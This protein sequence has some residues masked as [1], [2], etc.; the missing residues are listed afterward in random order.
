MDSKHS[1]K[2]FVLSKLFASIIAIILTLIGIILLLVSLIIPHDTIWPTFLELLALALIISG[3]INVIQRLFFSL[4]LYEEI[5]A[6]MATILQ[7]SLSSS[8][9]LI[10][11][12]NSLGIQQIYPNWS[13]FCEKILPER[14]ES[15]RSSFTAVGV[16]L[17]ELSVSVG[18]SLKKV[19]S[20]KLQEGK[21]F[22]FCTVKPDSPAAIYREKELLHKDLASSAAKSSLNYLTNLRNQ[23]P[24]SDFAIKTL[25]EVVPKFTFVCIDDEVLF[26]SPYFSSTPTASFVVIETHRGDSLFEKLKSDL[27]Y[28]LNIATDRV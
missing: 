23:H 6:D 25:E 2:R 16:G 10:N 28:L 12:C 18:S 20:K 15:L 19:V 24:G 4:S 27:D 26:I 14:I 5:R 3:S 17:P 11:S 1:L 13:A 22:T 8:F 21:K 7:D 9:A